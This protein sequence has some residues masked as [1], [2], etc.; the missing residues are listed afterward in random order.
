MNNMNNGSLQKY[1][2]IKREVLNS[3]DY[4]RSLVEEAYR[5]DVITEEEYK[6]IVASLMLILSNEV[7]RFTKG[8][9]SSVRTEVAKSLLDSICFKIGVTIKSIPDCSNAARMLVTTPLTELISIGERRINSYLRTALSFYKK[10]LANRIVTTNE[11]YNR[12]LDKEIKRFFKRY[13]K[14]FAAHDMTAALDLSYQLATPPRNT[15]D[16]AVSYL[17]RYEKTLY[18]ENEFC[19]LFLENDI[20]EILKNADPDGESQINIFEK[21]LYNSCANALLGDP[22]QLVLTVGDIEYLA[23]KFDKK[24]PEALLRASEVFSPKIRGWDEFLPG[25]IKKTIASSAG[26]LRNAINN[27]ALFSFFTAEG[28]KVEEPSFI[29]S[30]KRLSDEAFRDLADEIRFCDTIEKKLSLFSKVSSLSDFIDLLESECLYDD[31]YKQ[32]YSFLGEDIL[33]LLSEKAVQLED[34]GSSSEWV[35]EL[36]DFLPDE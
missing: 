36:A 26:L 28:A 18:W 20:K 33:K 19:S 3:D 4:M 13:N 29:D 32:F 2:P 6:S 25:Y 12:T 21:V 1:N 15:S 7:L 27:G 10:I 22:G 24:L 34:S 11:S 14:S 30:E 9:S 8:K 23:D 35:A 5:T 17:I 16:G 31:E